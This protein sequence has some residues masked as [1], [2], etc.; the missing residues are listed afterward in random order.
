MPDDCDTFT[1]HAARSGEISNLGQPSVRCIDLP[2]QE[3]ALALF[4]DFI[5]H[6]HSYNADNLHG[7]TVHTMIHGLYTQ[8]GQGQAIDLG[9]AALIL[10]FC[11][12]SAFFWDKDFPSTFNFLAEDKAA[13]SHTRG[14]GP[15]SIFWICVS[16]L[17]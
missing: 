4:E 5:V 13:G 11:A 16:G 10:S 7:P 9:S 3:D 2:S 8:L 17:P 1:F 14:E 15:R 6:T 12:A